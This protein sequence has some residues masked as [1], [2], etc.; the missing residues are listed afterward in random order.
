MRSLELQLMG[1]AI[2]DSTD[3]TN[4]PQQ[5]EDS[6]AQ[7]ARITDSLRRKR[8]ALGVDE[9][10]HLVSL[11][12]SAFLRIRMNACALKHRIRDRLR[13]RK[14]ELEKLER[15]YRHTVNGGKFQCIDHFLC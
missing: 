10:A 2:F 12:R 7:H 15:A 13:Q 5:L 8:A 6:R 1:D 4:I 14:F 11:R 9:R 3:S